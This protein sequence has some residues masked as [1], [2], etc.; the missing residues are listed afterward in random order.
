MRAWCQWLQFPLAG[1]YINLRGCGPLQQGNSLLYASIIFLE[2]KKLCC[3]PVI[4]PHNLFVWFYFFLGNWHFWEQFYKGPGP[5]SSPHCSILG[6]QA[7]WHWAAAACW[8]WGHTPATGGSS[9]L[10]GWPG[11][12]HPPLPRHVCT[13]KARGHPASLG[14]EREESQLGT[15]FLE[16]CSGLKQLWEVFWIQGTTHGLCSPLLLYPWMHLL[17]QT[18]FSYKHELLNQWAVSPLEA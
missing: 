7:T 8:G 17:S 10:A 15:K 11:S 14:R 3:A 16:G 4:H 12:L 13:H 6:C 2:E 18:D 1:I 5:V 9:S